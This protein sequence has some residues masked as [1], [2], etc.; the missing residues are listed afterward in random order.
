VQFTSGTI[1]TTHQNKALEYGSTLDPVVKLMYVMEDFIGRG[2][3]PE[4]I[5]MVDQFGILHAPFAQAR[6][7]LAEGGDVAG[8]LSCCHKVKEKKENGEETGSS[9]EGNDLLNPYRNLRIL[10]HSVETGQLVECDVCSLVLY[11]PTLFT[12]KKHLDKEAV[13]EALSTKQTHIVRK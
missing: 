5:V 3:Y 9:E 11:T 6:A 4:R 7:L 8:H 1:V 12:V 2:D 13:A 10:L